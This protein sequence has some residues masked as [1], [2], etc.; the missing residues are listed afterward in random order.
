ML[1]KLC[2]CLGSVK[3]KRGHRVAPFNSSFAIIRGFKCCL[4]AQSWFVAWHNILEKGS[5]L[6][7]WRDS[8][9]M[10][11]TRNKSYMLTPAGKNTRRLLIM[12]LTIDH[13]KFCLFLGKWRSVS[14]SETGALLTPAAQVTGG[15]CVLWAALC[16]QC[17]HTNTGIQTTSVCFMAL[18]P[19][20]YCCRKVMLEWTRNSLPQLSPWASCDPCEAR[21]PGGLIAQS[22][23]CRNSPAQRV[24]SCTWG[25]ALFTIPCSCCPQ[26]HSLRNHFI[27]RAE[28]PSWVKPSHPWDVQQ[29]MWVQVK[30]LKF[31]L[32]PAPELLIQ[33]IFVF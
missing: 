13:N 28:G 14:S 25:L 19:N 20:L 8:E 18:S 9:I 12:S 29:K 2:H 32:L 30:D 4:T 5:D 17:P 22:P 27:H 16:S 15:V 3:R 26:N 33:K 6:N 11:K 10:I 21:K 24:W 31:L 23:P 7:H 1:I